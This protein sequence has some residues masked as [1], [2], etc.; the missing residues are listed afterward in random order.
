MAVMRSSH[1]V[2][3]C[4]ICS[5][6]VAVASSKVCARRLVK[7]TEESLKALTGP[8]LGVDAVRSD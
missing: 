7:L 1:V 5:I 8:L 4:S 6:I 2:P 3:C